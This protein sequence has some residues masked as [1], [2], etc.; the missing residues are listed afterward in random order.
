[1][2]TANP[3]KTHL[4]ARN[5]ALTRAVRNGERAADDPALENCRRQLAEIRLT[6]YVENIVANWPRLTDEQIDRIAGLLRS[7]RPA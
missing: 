2:A 1:M 5:A 4:R 3:E 7:G 6:E